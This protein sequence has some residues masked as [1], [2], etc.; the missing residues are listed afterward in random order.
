MRETLLCFALRQKS[1]SWINRLRRPAARASTKGRICFALRR[2]DEIA[3]QIAR[4]NAPLAQRRHE[5]SDRPNDGTLLLCPTSLAPDRCRAAYPSRQGQPF[6][7][8]GVRPNH[9]GAGAAWRRS[10]GAALKPIRRG[11][12]GVPSCAYPVS[13]IAI[14]SLTV[15]GLHAKVRGAHILNAEE[16]LTRSRQ[17]YAAT[18]QG[19]G[20][21]I[22]GAPCRMPRPC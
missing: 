22:P 9:L 5:E 1:P 8:C 18:I 6:R 19:V 12:R 7:D 17:R 20:A 13:L 4:V 15:N 2:R 16:F 21:R 11:T 10:L 3:S 14:E